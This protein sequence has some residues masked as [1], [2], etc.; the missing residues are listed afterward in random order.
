MI[1]LLLVAIFSLLTIRR[2]HKTKY[3]DDKDK[4]RSKS[5]SRKHIFSRKKD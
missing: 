1:F 3:D 5:R 2:I 4:A